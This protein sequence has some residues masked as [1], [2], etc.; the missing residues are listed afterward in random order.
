MSLSLIC[1]V[2][3]GDNTCMCPFS[4]ELAMPLC[5]MGA[6]LVL[7]L[8][9][10]CLVYLLSDALT[11]STASVPEVTGNLPVRKPETPFCIKKGMTVKLVL[12]THKLE[13]AVRKHAMEM[14]E[15]GS[16]RPLCGRYHPL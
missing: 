1:P 9:N 8:V 16:G 12:M 5:C 14:I 2:V 6:F 15:E 7:M 4:V 11:Q 3:R 13:R 10:T